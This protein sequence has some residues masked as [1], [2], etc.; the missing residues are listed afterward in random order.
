MK[1]VTNK[2]FDENFSPKIIAAVNIQ[3]QFE[4]CRESIPQGLN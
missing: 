2:S 4:H 1:D 3:V